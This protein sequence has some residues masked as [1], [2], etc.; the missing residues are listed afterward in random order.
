MKLIGIGLAILTIVGLF[1]AEAILYHLCFETGSPISIKI[2]LIAI[3]VGVL[4]L[5][6]GIVRDELKPAA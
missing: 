1:F 4:F 6:I 2:A 3:A 5:F